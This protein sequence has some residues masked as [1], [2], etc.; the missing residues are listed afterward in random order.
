MSSESRNLDSLDI[1]SPSAKQ[2]VFSWKGSGT[3]Y[4]PGSLTT[5]FAYSARSAEQMSQ[6]F[7]CVNSCD[8]IRV[9]RVPQ[10]AAL[11]KNGVSAM[12]VTH[13]APSKGTS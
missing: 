7:T 8:I 4:K 6:E 3:A 10:Q 11:A 2:L 12:Q 9:I 1:T 5:V 13:P